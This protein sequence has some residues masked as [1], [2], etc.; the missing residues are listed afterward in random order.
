[1][2]VVSAYLALTLLSDEASRMLMLTLIRARLMVKECRHGSGGGVGDGGCGTKM[3]QGDTPSSKCYT[4]FPPPP[5]LIYQQ[6]QVLRL[7]THFS[8]LLT[9]HK[10]HLTNY[11]VTLSNAT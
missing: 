8:Y 2:D 1:M 9:Q 4:Y 3:V 7:P 11:S 5:I 6:A 10:L